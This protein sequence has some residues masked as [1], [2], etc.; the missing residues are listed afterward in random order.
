MVLM[1]IVV[2]VVGLVLDVDHVALGY[3]DMCCVCAL[4]TLPSDCGR[5]AV[6]RPVRL[7][8]QQCS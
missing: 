6:G 8:R 4:Q 2:M 1:T 5:T 3:H 7:L